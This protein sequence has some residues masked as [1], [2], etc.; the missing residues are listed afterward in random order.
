MRSCR[1]LVPRSGLTAPSPFRRASCC[2][3]WSDH[4]SDDCFKDPLIAR[5][6][7]SRLEVQRRRRGHHLSATRQRRSTQWCAPC[8]NRIGRSSIINSSDWGTRYLLET[9]GSVNPRVGGEPKLLQLLFGF[10]ARRAFAC[11][12]HVVNDVPTCVNFIFV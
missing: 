11:V 2:I 4:C 8:L 12:A 10:A 5:Y 1:A 9:T 7:A 3:S 6:W